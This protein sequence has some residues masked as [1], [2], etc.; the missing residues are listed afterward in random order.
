MTVPLARLAGLL[1]DPSRAAFCLALLDGRAWTAGELARHAGIAPST[2]SAHVTLLVDGGVLADERQGRHR[3]VRLADPEMA[4]LIEE[5]AVRAEGLAEVR[6]PQ[7]LREVTRAKA[8]ARA[9]TCYDHLAGRL[10]VAITGAMLQRRLLTGAGFA[11]TDAGL[12]WLSGLDIDVAALDKAKRPFARQCLD[13]TERRPHLAGAAG[14][15]LCSQAF[16]RQWVER[17]GGGRAVR[18]TPEGRNAFAAQLGLD[19]KQWS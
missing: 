19:E 18:V 11:F 14:A 15:A 7:G 9:R 16:S 5:L 3:Y 4:A 2:A 13:W 10:G 17:I 8:I 1:A 6:P 12:V